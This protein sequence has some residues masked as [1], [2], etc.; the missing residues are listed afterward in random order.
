MK[1][2]AGAILAGALWT[3][4]GADGGTD[5]IFNIDLI[6]ATNNPDNFSIAGV[7]T[8][9][10]GSRTYN[11]SCSTGQANISLGTELLDGSIRLQVWDGDGDLV[12]DNTYEAVLIGGV[13]VF[14][15]SQPDPVA[16]ETWTLKFTFNDAFWTGALT[17]KAD[18]FPDP[19]EISIGGTG[20]DLD[21]SWIF[22]PGWDGNDVNISIGGVTGG[23]IR[24]RIWDGGAT[25][26]ED[27]TVTTGATYT[28]IVTGVA[29]VWMVQIDFTNAAGAGAITVGQ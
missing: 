9:Y 24:V 27:A 25:L 14:T 18:T 16:P 22:E 21:G 10:S 17:V 3:G 12:H 19:D 2:L 7:S 15:K 29:G 11:W 5:L 6:V 20:A 23:T 8:S 28:N 4:C 13:N 26:K 1:R